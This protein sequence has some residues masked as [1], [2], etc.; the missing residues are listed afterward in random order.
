MIGAVICLNQV[1]KQDFQIR[2]ASASDNARLAFY[3]RH[4][5]VRLYDLHAGCELMSLE[6][7]KNFGRS[8]IAV[9]PS[10]EMIAAATYDDGSVSVFEDSGKQL[11]S[12]NGLDEI[13]VVAF[14]A[15]SELLYCSHHRGIVSA[16][17]SRNGSPARFTWFKK[18]VAGSYRLYESPYDDRFIND[19]IE[20]SL[21]LITKSLR[22]V[23]TIERKTFAVLDTAFAPEFVCISET[24]GPVSCYHIDGTEVWELAHETSAHALKLSYASR[25]NVFR[26]ITMPYEDRCDQFLLTVQPAT[27]EIVDTKKLP[28]DTSLYFAVNGTMLVSTNGQLIDAQSLQKVGTVEPL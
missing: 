28:D 16:F 21:N 13:K 1:N 17:N 25:D 24:G 6:S 19:R 18:Q 12:R 9:S 4:H 23:R 3:T 20:N 22:V 14:S 15:D 27:G 5:G 8:R 11:W 10:G 2:D 26:A 7:R